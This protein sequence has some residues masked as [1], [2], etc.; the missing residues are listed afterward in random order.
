MSLAS[1]AKMKYWKS[2]ST[3]AVSSGNC[4][5]ISADL[6]KDRKCMVL[7]EGKIFIQKARFTTFSKA[8]SIVACS[9]V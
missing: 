1:A 8:S 3:S 9:A 5:M 6:E 4:A 2:E 7:S